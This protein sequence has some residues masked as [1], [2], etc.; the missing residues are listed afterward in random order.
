MLKTLTRDI[1]LSI[2]AKSG[3]SGAVAVWMGVVAIA[4]HSPASASSHRFAG[5][6]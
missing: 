2:Q 1:A 6:K 3:A 4:L 5:S